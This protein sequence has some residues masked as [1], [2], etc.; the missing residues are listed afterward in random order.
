MNWLKFPNGS[1]LSPGRHREWY[2]NSAIMADLLTD[3]V[4][5]FSAAPKQL[6]QDD[7]FK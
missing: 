4:S 2:A 3:H 6:D 5:G 1:G 7:W